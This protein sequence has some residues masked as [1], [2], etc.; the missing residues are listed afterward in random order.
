MKKSGVEPHWGKGAQS[1]SICAG[2]EMEKVSREE[3]RQSILYSYSMEKKP[4]SAS[5]FSHE[6]LSD[7]EAAANCLPT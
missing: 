7:L 6:T 3:K 1:E 4:T 2:S 5:F